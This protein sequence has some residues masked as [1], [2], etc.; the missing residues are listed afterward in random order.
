[1]TREKY[2]IITGASCGLGKCFA[3]ICAAKGINLILTALPGE[4][5]I[6]QAENYSTKF[7]I[8]AISH[9]ADLTSLNQLSGFV[10]WINNSFEVYIL[11]N[12]AG[13]GGALGFGAA[14]GEYISTMLD[15]NICAPVKLIHGLL[16]NLERQGEAY[17]LNVASMASFG[18][19]PF[20][21]VYPAS[22]VFLYSFSRGLNTELKGTGVSVS[23]VHPGGMPTNQDVSARI[24]KH[25]RLVRS[26]ILSPERVAE[27]SFRGMMKNKPVIIPGPMNKI[28]WFL[29]KIIPLGLRMY[30]F[31]KLMKK[32]IG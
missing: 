26:T 15:L 21:T 32:E 16:A 18:P 27:I 2:A 4:G 19:M 3:G 25:N 9:E 29:F 5:V 6:D 20:K 8:K 24:N 23:V 30:I 11:I 12:N 10:N 14:P 22:K 1:M 13:L 17:I 28:S 31:R 7:G